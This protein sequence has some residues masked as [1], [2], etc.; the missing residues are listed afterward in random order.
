MTVEGDREDVGR[1]KGPPREDVDDEA[2]S[3]RDKGVR[4]RWSWSGWL[5]FRGERTEPRQRQERR[6]RGTRG[7]PPKVV[8]RGEECRLLI[9]S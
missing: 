4:E 2:R 6:A 1:A 3:V 9:I 7:G 5:S 8:R